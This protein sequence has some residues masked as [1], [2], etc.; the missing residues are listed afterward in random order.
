MRARLL[1]APLH[2]AVALEEV[3]GVA[4]GVRKHLHLD[5]ARRLDEALQQHALIAKRGAR[6]PPRRVDCLLRRP[7]APSA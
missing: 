4:C 1:V 7:C 2:G 6:L 5:V 3:D